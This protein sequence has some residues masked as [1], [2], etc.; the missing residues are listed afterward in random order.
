MKQYRIML[1]DDDPIVLKGIGHKL[2]NQG[3]QVTCC[4]SGQGSL[5]QIQKQP[6]DLVIT[7][8]HMEPIS[9]IDVLRAT[10]SA[11]PETSVIILTGY[12]DLASAIEALRL[13]ADDFILKNCGPEE[14]IFRVARSLEKSELQQKVRAAEKALKEA[15]EKLEYKVRERTA[16]LSRAFDQRKLLSKRLIELL[17]SDRLYVAGELHDQIGQSLSSLRT[18]LGRIRTRAK[19]CCPELSAPLSAS[20]EAIKAVIV[21]LRNIAHGLRPALLDSLGLVPCLKSHFQDL[22]SQHPIQIVFFHEGVPQNM[23]RDLSLAVYR[24]AQEAI[25][26]AVKYSRTP[27]IYVTLMKQRQRLVLSVEDEGAGFD[28]ERVM[29]NQGKNRPLGILIMQER[30]VQLGGKFN[31]DSQ[32]GGG[33]TVLAEFPLT[34]LGG[35]N[36]AR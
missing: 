18:E 6:F 30:A 2:E 8:L 1:A 27:Q 26:N 28:P 16:Q 12:G 10:K 24:I 33:T 34:P 31:V 7:D 35:G 36:A 5:E 22:E 21:N 29:Q 11:S 15:N 14:L 3:Y 17:E 25:M 13:D 23:G 19:R 32:S 20:E 4:D 9:G